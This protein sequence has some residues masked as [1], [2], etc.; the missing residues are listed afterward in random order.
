M[1]ITFAECGS[2]DPDPIL[3]V[4]ENPGSGSSREKSLK[5]FISYL[6]NT[7][8]DFVPEVKRHLHEASKSKKFKKIFVRR[9][10]Y[11]FLI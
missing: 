5:R 4:F 3:K 9:E 1:Q 8:R 2:R 7:A 11:H 10:G 6:N